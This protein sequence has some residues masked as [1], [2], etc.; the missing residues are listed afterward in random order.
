MG[1]EIEMGT[2]EDRNR[3]KDRRNRD[4]D[5]NSDEYW[6]GEGMQRN[7][8]KIVTGKKEDQRKPA[9]ISYKGLEDFYLGPGVQLFYYRTTV[10]CTEYPRPYTEQIRHLTTPLLF[11]SAFLMISVDF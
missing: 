7:G 8:G 4:E 1:S 3:D 11:L 6:E 10:H 2:E 5:G 9:N